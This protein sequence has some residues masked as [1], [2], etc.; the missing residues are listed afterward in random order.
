MPFSFLSLSPILSKQAIV[1]QVQPF[2]IYL[3]IYL[4]NHR[5]FAWTY[6]QPWNSVFL[7]QQ[8]SFSRLISRRNHQPIMAVSWSGCFRCVGQ[9]CVQKPSTKQYLDVT[10]IS[11]CN[12]NNYFATPLSVCMIGMFPMRWSELCLEDVWRRRMIYL[13]I[14]FW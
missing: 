14:D 11:M 7:S 10:K 4:A 1:E 13:L 9:S 5:L 8:I 2:I 12:G 3:L 6:Q